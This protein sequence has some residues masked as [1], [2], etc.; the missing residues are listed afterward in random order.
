MMAGK[1][2]WAKQDLEYFPILKNGKKRNSNIKKLEIMSRQTWLY[3][4]LLSVT[5]LRA[6]AIAIMM[7]AGPKIVDMT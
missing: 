7:V 1:V 2:A 4:K 3:H 5:A 6:S